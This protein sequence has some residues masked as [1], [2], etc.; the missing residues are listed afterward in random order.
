MGQ[1]I[2]DRNRFAAEIG[3]FWAGYL[4]FRR[5]DLWAGG[6]WLT[7][8]DNIAFVPELRMNVQAT[9]NWLRSGCDLTLPFPALS[10][11]ATHRRLIDVDDGSGEQFWFP[12]WGPITDNISGHVF[13]DRENLTITLEF[14]RETHRIAAE[15]KLVF[16][17]ELP[18]AELVGVLEQMLTA[19]G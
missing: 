12:V 6:H 11:A 16:E 9:V 3:E 14:W 17:V 19:L 10:P 1:L 7:C 2:G 5:V 8:D 15:R 4:E 18:E 13:R